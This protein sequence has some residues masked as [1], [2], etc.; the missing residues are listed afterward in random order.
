MLLTYY[1]GD[2][3][4][5]VASESEPSKPAK[6]TSKQSTKGAQSIK[7]AGREFNCEFSDKALCVLILR[8]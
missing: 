7:P 3:A 4:S 5:E 2:T 1:E 6:I 8:M